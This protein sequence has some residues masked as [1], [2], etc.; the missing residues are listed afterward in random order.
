MKEDRH[1][2]TAVVWEQ[3]NLT[4]LLSFAGV[5]VRSAVRGDRELEAGVEFYSLRL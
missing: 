1:Y 5:R 2:A 3:P 4:L